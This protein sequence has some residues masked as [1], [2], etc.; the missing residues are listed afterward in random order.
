M[1]VKSRRS[2]CVARHSTR[3]VYI[4]YIICKTI[5]TLLVIS[6]YFNLVRFAAD[7][8]NLV[9]NHK[10]VDAFNEWDHKWAL[11]E[12]NSS[13]RNFTWTNN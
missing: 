4:L 3:V 1:V 13:D 12:L 7:K 8:S 5:I 2:L 6:S 9:I 10:W 11:V